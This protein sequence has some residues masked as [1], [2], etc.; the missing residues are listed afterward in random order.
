L[1]KQVV[2]N[3]RGPTGDGLKPNYCRAPMVLY[4]LTPCSW[5]CKHRYSSRRTGR[6]ARIPGKFTQFTGFTRIYAQ[7]A[8]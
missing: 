2:Q 6:R 3:I 8:L 5:H 7:N 1:N 4:G